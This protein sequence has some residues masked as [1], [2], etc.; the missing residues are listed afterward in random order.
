MAQYTSPCIKEL[1]LSSADRRFLRSAS[2]PSQSFRQCCSLAPGR[3]CGVPLLRARN[4]H[5][6]VEYIHLNPVRGGSVG[7]PQNWRW[8]SFNEFADVL[9]EEQVQRRENPRRSP[10]PALIATTSSPSGCK[11]RTRQPTGSPRHLLF[12]SPSLFAAIRMAPNPRLLTT[13]QQKLTP[14]PVTG[15]APF[16]KQ[17]RTGTH[18]APICALPASRTEVEVLHPGAKCTSWR[19]Y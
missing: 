8:S 18:Q 12:A 17:R 9:P 5:E 15:R 14:T 2:F 4:Y 13:Y 6:K 3:S 11:M 1:N 16:P 10:H 7:H 19:A